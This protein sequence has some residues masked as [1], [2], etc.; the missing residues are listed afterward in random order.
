MRGTEREDLAVV[1]HEIDQSHTDDGMLISRGKAKIFKRD[2]IDID[3]IS[4]WS[5]DPIP[6]D[7]EAINEA[8]GKVIP[9]FAELNAA[10][11][12]GELFI[13][14]YPEGK[15][16]DDLMD[17]KG[18]DYAGFKHVAVK[19]DNGGV[20]GGFVAVKKAGMSSDELFALGLRAASFIVGQANMTAINKSLGN[21]QSDV[22]EVLA[23]MDR[24]NL[25]DLRALKSRLDEFGV[26][27][28]RTAKED[29]LYRSQI[30]IDSIITDLGKI[31]Q[32]EM[33]NIESITDSV[34]HSSKF[35]V[36][37]AHEQIDKF[38]SA[39]GRCTSALCLEAYARAL[40][41]AYERGYSED[42]IDFH[43]ASLSKKNKACVELCQRALRLL[44]RELG[45]SGASVFAKNI[46][47][48]AYDANDNRR[49]HTSP[50]GWVLLTF[51]Y[52]A[53]SEMEQRRTIDRRVLQT[54]IPDCTIADAFIE[55]VEDNFLHHGSDAIVI[56]SDGMRPLLLGDTD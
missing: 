37:E 25:S 7:L 31:F 43:Y 20:G 55:A 24:K 39:S 53:S 9:D 19:A 40:L 30:A 6:V 4:K 2:E 35:N 46:L 12:R 41:I 1:P 14:R 47:S 32:G 42:Y 11:S 48:Q 22:N 56:A 3:A 5:P 13:L 15:G 18:S 34:A 52:M 51:E 26:R 8:I 16:L 54:K 36:A 21:I 45:S 29:E 50:V 27:L 44:E 10:L 28:G 38:V 23:R 33:D 17:R 49:H